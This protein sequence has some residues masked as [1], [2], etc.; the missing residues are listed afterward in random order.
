[1]RKKLLMMLA[2]LGVAVAMV[3]LVELGLRVAGVGGFDPARDSRLKY[4]QIFQPTFRPAK[5]AYGREVLATADP[6]L[7][8]QWIAPQK[9]ANALR[10]LVFGESAISGLGFSPNVTVVRE[11]E[12]Q[13]CA[14][15]PDRVLEVINLGI[16]ALPSKQVRRLVEEA[17]EHYAP[18]AVVIYCGNNEFLEIHAEK[19]ADHIASGGEKVLRALSRSH[20][21]GALRGLARPPSRVPNVSTSDVADNDQRVSEARMIEFV[22]VDAIERAE[23]VA[24]HAEN[25]RAMAACCAAAKVPCVIAAVAV[26]WEWLGRTDPPAEWIEAYCGGASGEAGL[27]HALGALRAELA[28]ASERE[29]Y[30]THWRM[31]EVHRR[32]GEWPEAVAQYRASLNGDPHLRRCRDEMNEGA[33]AAAR[34]TGVGFV[35]TPRE[36]AAL[37][38]HGMVGFGDFYDY[39][40]FTPRGAARTAWLVYGELARLQVFTPAPEHDA[41][42]FLAAREAKF[43][44]LESDAKAVGDF[45]G[46]G[47][48]P[49][50]IV[51]RDL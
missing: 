22:G 14:A 16:V 7:P 19:Y 5:L 48:S 37:D 3:L 45:L 10:V 20:I 24:R 50:R 49:R 17:V 27:R 6:R 12:R 33:L 25:L 4:Q 8:Y 39:V 26:N 36:L 47:S 9:P 51:D 46:I 32:L 28:S 23:L 34:A 15:C 18:D 13:L 29:R 2:T 11:L 42:A 43:A 41:R 44:A 35:D 38:E 31:G 30:L 40:H 1:M 21:Y